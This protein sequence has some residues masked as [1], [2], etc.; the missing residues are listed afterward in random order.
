MIIYNG[1]NPRISSETFD[2][3]KIRISNICELISES[4]YSIHDLSRLKAKKEGE[5]YRLN[6]PFELGIDYG[7]RLFSGGP[8]DNKKHLILEAKKYEYMKAISDLSGFDI[9]SHNNEPEMVVKTI[10]NWFVET[11]GMFPVES[12]TKIWYKFCDFASDFY[13]KRKAEGF[14]DSDLNM[15]PVPE[16]IKYM[17]EWIRLN[18]K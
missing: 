4:Q 8:Y 7:C 17:K 14:S 5:Y 15:M 16:Y 9:K 6:M 10:R 18:K 12:S 13:D 1:L 11:L 2:S 3:G